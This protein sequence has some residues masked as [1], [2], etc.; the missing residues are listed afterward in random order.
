[1]VELATLAEVA[2]HTEDLAADVEDEEGAV[3]LDA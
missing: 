1:V 2:V 3:E